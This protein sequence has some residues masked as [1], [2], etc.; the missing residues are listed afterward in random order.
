MKKQKYV[1]IRQNNQA[2]GN[3]PKKRL[4]KEIQIQ[5]P[6]HSYRNPI[7]AKNKNQLSIHKKTC[8]VNKNKKEKTL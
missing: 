6:T 7:K 4:K 5:S 8:R 1:G 3:E 2:E